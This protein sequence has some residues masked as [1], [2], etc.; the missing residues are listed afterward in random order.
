VADISNIDHLIKFILAIANIARPESAKIKYLFLFFAT[1]GCS[2][3][4][5]SGDRQ[6]NCQ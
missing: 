3:K 4:P 2:Y 1:L 6:S 5:D